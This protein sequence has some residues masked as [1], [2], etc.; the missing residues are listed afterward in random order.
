M[1]RCDGRFT[2]ACVQSFLSAVENSTQY[3][4]TDQG[5]DTAFLGLEA[6]YVAYDFMWDLRRD[7]KFKGSEIFSMCDK[8]CQFYVLHPCFYHTDSFSE[9]VW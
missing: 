6:S 5:Y 3:V 8:V 7:K 4:V 1:S 9:L 2:G